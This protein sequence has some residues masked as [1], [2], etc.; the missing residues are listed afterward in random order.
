MLSLG[1]DDIDPTAGTKVPVFVF[2]SNSWR[3]KPQEASHTLVVTDGILL[4]GGGGDPFVD[5]NGSYVVRINYQQ[6]VQAIAFDSGGSGGLTEA[7][8]AQLMKTL[9]LAKFLALK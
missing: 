6:P 8:N 2:L 7:Q 1:G 3:I 4:V 9:T 5:T